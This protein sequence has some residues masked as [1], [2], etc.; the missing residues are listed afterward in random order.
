MQSHVTTSKEYIFIKQ[1]GKGGSG[2]TYLAKEISTQRD[3]AIK[4][5]PTQQFFTEVEEEEIQTSSDLSPTGG[6]NYYVPI[7]YTA[8]F[9]FGEKA[10]NAFI[11]S[12]YIEGGTMNDFLLNLVKGSIIPPNKLWSLM[13]QLMLG[14]RYIHNKGYAHNDIKPEN[15]I[16]NPYGRIRYIDFGASCSNDCE[17][18]GASLA[19]NSPE[20]LRGTMEHS[21]KASLAQD[22]WSLGILLFQICN[23]GRFPF[24]LTFPP[25][26]FAP[27]GLEQNIIDAPKYKSN[28]TRDDGRT[29]IFLNKIIINDQKVRPTIQ[30]ML[31]IFLELVSSNI[32]EYR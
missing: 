20:N 31:D 8:F 22:C 24:D 12:E 15:I 30:E 6:I 18:L 7:F 5:I 11:V 28:Y 16:I 4:V 27:E 14:L 23:S 29:N 1:L 10:H 25:P 21:L 26:E 3:V 19:Y 9:E 17:G 13:T 32:Y 2:T